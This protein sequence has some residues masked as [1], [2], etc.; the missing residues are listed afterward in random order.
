MNSES[1]SEDSMT[2]LAEAASR[3]DI[4]KVKELIARVA[5]LEEISER[6]FYDVIHRMTALGWAVIS[7]SSPE[8]ISVLTAASARVDTELSI[9][10]TRRT[11]LEHVRFMKEQ[12]A[13][14]EDGPGLLGF[15]GEFWGRVPTAAWFNDVE[16]ILSQA[17]AARNA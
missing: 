6:D 7:W 16:R 14:K 12:L 10:E 15:Q 9:N 17:K 8:L 11:P 1:I 5:A 4:A 3:D 2:E 13:D